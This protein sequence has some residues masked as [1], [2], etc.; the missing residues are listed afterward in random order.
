MISAGKRFRAL[1]AATA[2]GGGSGAERAPFQV[3]G[4]VNAYCALMAEKKGARAL[5]LSG[6]GVATASYGLPDLGITSLEMV[7]EDVRRITAATRLP[8]LVDVDTGFGGAFN[9][10]RTVREMERA[11]AAAVHME[12]QVAAK[13]CGHRPGK[14]LVPVDEMVDRIRAAVDARTD[15]DFV[16]MAR[17]D[18]LSVE[19]LESA[20]DRM[21]RYVAAGADCLFPEA[22]SQLAEYRALGE[23]LPGVPY[24]ANITEFGRTPL[25]SVPEL[26]SAGVAMVL[27][28]LSAHRAMARAAERVYEA[29]IRDGHQREVLDTM[30]TREELYEFLSYHEYEQ[31][32][33]RLF[34][35]GKGK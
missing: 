11:G 24:L 29:I 25:H 23:R 14:Q 27:Y 19:G 12:D 32:L 20:L 26:G 33:D 28:P 2:Q 30:Q 4:A 18:A 6:S 15:P 8:L 35:A 31:T 5:Y 16:I 3:L 1:L 21:E 9:I 34:D 7:T 22:F 13:R 17:C 10:K